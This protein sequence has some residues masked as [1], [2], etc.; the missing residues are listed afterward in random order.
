M[1]VECLILRIVSLKRSWAPAHDGDILS[2]SL[3]YTGFMADIR[4]IRARIL[5]IA[6]RRK[7]VEL[8]D[9][10]WVVNHLG[11]NGYRV[12]SKSN[13]H[14][15]LFRVNARRFGVCHHNPGSK[16]IKPCYV[17][18]FLDAMADLDLYEA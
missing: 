4:H 5:D 2:V 12:S 10:Q 8:Q 15:Y 9:I 16:Q 1:T 7:N 17:D 18:E 14:Q 13:Q 3:K 11:K 6:Q